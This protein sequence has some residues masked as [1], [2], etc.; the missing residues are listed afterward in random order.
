M[1]CTKNKIVYIQKQKDSIAYK[2]FLSLLIVMHG[3][4]NV[5]CTYWLISTVNAGNIGQ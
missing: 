4:R 5:Q 3:W 1:G 2:C